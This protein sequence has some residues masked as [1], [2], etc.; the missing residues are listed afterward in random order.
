MLKEMP[1]LR[2]T[3][4]TVCHSPKASNILNSHSKKVED[5]K[6]IKKLGSGKFGEVYLVK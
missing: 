4:S 6:K 3:G 2:E 5:F 1:K